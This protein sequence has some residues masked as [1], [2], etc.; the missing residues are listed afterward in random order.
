MAHFQRPPVSVHARW[1][2]LRFSIVGPLLAAPPEAGTLSAEIEALT[3]KKWQHPIT[4]APTQFG[5]STIERWFYEARAQT[6]PVSAL[7]RKV[8][9]DAG[10][11][12]KMP[13]VLRETLLQQYR[14]HPS[15]S[16][17]LHADNL[18]A[19]AKVN[20]KEVYVPSYSTLRRFMK[21]KGLTPRPRRGPL[22][23]PG[24]LLA[25][26]RLFSKEV[27]SYEAAYVNALWHTDFHSGSRKVLLPS[28]QWAVPLILA[29]LDDYSRL[30]CHAQW[31]LSDGE[32]TDIF[33]HGLCQAIQ[34]RD[35]PRALMTDGGPSMTAAETTEGLSRVGIIHDQTLPYSPDQNGKQEVFW[36]QVEGRLLA[37]IEGVKDLTLEL[38]NEAT[39]AWVEL[40]YNRKRHSEIHQTPLDRYLS[41]TSIGRPS[42][43]SPEL[44]IVFTQERTRTQRRSDGTISVEGVRFEIPNRYRSLSRVTIRYARWDLGRVLLMDARRGTVLCPIYPL[45]KTKN[46][47][48]L[49]RSLEP[50]DAPVIV[51]PSEMAPLLKQLMA[52]YAAT[53]LP[54]AYL[55]KHAESNDE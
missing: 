20:W 35:L 12:R 21:Q 10:E 11:P 17:Q 45:D 13:S 48:G 4:Q 3:E 54:P 16:Y 55:P 39:Q 7:R 51:A 40:E 53:G 1:A 30:C 37:M 44:R 36:A 31:Y 42:P 32:S 47:D 15:W 52:E 34:K 50:L 33:I 24:G 46:A 8:R 23:S 2:H 49:R 43:S 5:F 41:G 18:V 28:G 29:V 27:R 19:L 14:E 25:E 9:H 26:Q 6:D 38:L 22:G